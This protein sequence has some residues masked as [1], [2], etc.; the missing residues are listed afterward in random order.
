FGVAESELPPKMSMSLGSASLTPLSVARGYAV[1]AY[2]GSRVDTWL[3]DQ[4]NDRDC[5]LVFKENP[6]LACRDCA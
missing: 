6:A 2:G 5:N 3:I 4:V 1:F